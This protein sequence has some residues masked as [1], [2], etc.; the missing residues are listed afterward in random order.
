MIV[1]NLFCSGAMLLLFLMFLGFVL[2]RALNLTSI[3]DSLW[4][5][6]PV[7]MA[8]YLLLP[9]G[10]SWLNFYTLFILSLWALRL[11]L[12]IFMTRLLK[13][14]E[15]PRYEK[16]L[17]RV[18]AKKKNR[19]IFFQFMFQGFLQILISLSFL[20]FVWSQGEF[21]LSFVVI[22]FCFSFL[23][24]IGEAY[25]DFEL[26]K[27]KKKQKKG[28]LMTGFWAYSRHPNYFCDW[29]F[30]LGIGFLGCSLPWGLLSFIA[31]ILMWIIFNYLTGP[32]TERMSLSKYPEIYSDYQ[33]RVPFMIP[34]FFR[35]RPRL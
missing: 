35:G 5:L 20:P 33:K 16:I 10:F 25:A 19:A 28:V 30:W 34:S 7:F 21:Y 22:G 11:S 23:A 17:S 6:G 15:D 29:C 31:A 3:I 14:H 1:F 32:L 4:P 9:I 13:K 26:F 2:S 12:F 18:E 27:F 24:I 8:C